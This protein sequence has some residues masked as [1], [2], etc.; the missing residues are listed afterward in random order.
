LQQ[1]LAEMGG[2]ENNCVQGEEMAAAAGENKV[3]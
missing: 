2:N 1:Q 3:K